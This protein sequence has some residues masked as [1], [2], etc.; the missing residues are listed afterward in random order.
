MSRCNIV[1]AK[2]LLMPLMW[3]LSSLYTRKS[4][5]H[6]CTLWEM[7]PTVHWV[8]ILFCLDLDSLPLQ[9][10]F[11]LLWVFKY[12]QELNFYDTVFLLC[13]REFPAEECNGHILLCN[14]CAHLSWWG[15]SV[16]FKFFGV[17]RVGQNYIFC[18]DCLYIIICFL[19]Y[20]IPMPRDLPGLQGF[21]D[22]GMTTLSYQWGE[23][24][25]SLHIAQ[26][27]L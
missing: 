26:R 8:R 6:Q 23:W 4:N 15:I 3:I 10:A 20:H 25:K 2:V 21:S 24:G 16:D 17:I 19:M 12:G 11:E 13:F 1:L 27:S 9:Y 7:R 22:F 18:N 14:H 5:L